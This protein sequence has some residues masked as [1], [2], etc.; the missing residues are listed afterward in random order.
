LRG[1]I[2]RRYFTAMMVSLVFFLSRGAEAGESFRPIKKD[3]YPVEDAVLTGVHPN[4][5]FLLDT[6]SS[7]TF[8]PSGI[9]PDTGD[10][11]SVATRKALVDAGATYGAG[12]RPFTAGG[13]EKGADSW[14]SRYGRDVYQRNNIIGN[15]DCYYTPFPN[16]PY[17]LT[18][19]NPAWA[20]W[21]G[22][23]AY[24]ANFPGDLKP[25][26]PGGAREGNPVPANLTHHLIPNDSRMYQMKLALW[27]ILGQENAETF[28]AMRVAMATS[29]KEETYPST[30]YAD[31]YFNP[32][33]NGSWPVRG[34]NWLG[35]GTN[36]AGNSA[37]AGIW[38]DYYGAGDTSQKWA[39]VNRAVLTAPFDYIYKQKIAGDGSLSYIA[40]DNLARIHE[41]L[42]GIEAGNSS[43]FTNR[44]LYAD[45]KT[46][47]ATSIYSRHI[48]A[49]RTDTAN[50]PV[51][52]YA[53]QIAGNGYGAGRIKFGSYNMHIELS[54]FPVSEDL[55][56]NS[57]TIRAG[58]ALG[59]VIDFF[60]PPSG[61]LAYDSAPNST[62]TSNT[63]GYFP[64]LGSCQ[65]NWLVV[66]TAAN[67]STRGYTAAQAA[68]RLFDD[69]RTHMR[70]R[71][72]NGTQWVEQ[73]FTMD[74]GIRTLV[75]GMVDPDTNDPLVVD[76]RDSLNELARAGD[77]ILSNGVYVPN[78]H[79]QA[80]FATDVPQ[81]M[82][83]LNSIL[84]RISAR[85]F[86][87]G[88]PVVMP[89]ETDDTNRKV[90]F[91]SS[92][93]INTMDQWDAWFSRYVM[94]GDFDAS[95]AWEFNNGA[96]VP[97]HAARSIYTP[98]CPKGDTNTTSTLLQAIAPSDMTALTGVPAERV[99]DF[100]TWLRDY[101]GLQI[102]GD[103]ENSGMQYVGSPDVRPLLDD[104]LVG[105][106]DP[107]VYLQTNRGV[108][109]AVNY[110]NGS[111]RWAFFPPN[112]F[113]TRLRALKFSRD[114]SWH[115]GD[116]VNTVRSVAHNL[117]DGP[118]TFRDVAVNAA[119]TDYRTILIGNMGWGGNGLYAMD[120][121]TPGA[122]PQFLWAVE[123][124]RYDGGPSREVGL[125]GKS[126]AKG[127][128]TAPYAQLGLTIAPTV[129][130]S[131]DVSATDRRD[132]AVL[133]GGMGYN[134]GSDDQGKALYVIDPSDGDVLRAFTNTSG[135]VGPKGSA[136]GMGVAPIT[137]TTESAAF[138]PA[139]GSEGKTAFFT[140]DSEGNVLYCNTAPE[141]ASWQLRS[142]FQLKSAAGAPVAIPKAI[143]VGKNAK[144]NIWLFGGSAPL[145]AP[146]K[147]SEGKQRGIL[148][149]QNCIFAFNWTKTSFDPELTTETPGM[150]RLKY[151]KDNSPLMPP[152]GEDLVSGDNSFD[153]D[154]IKGWY[155]PL[156]PAQSM[157]AMGTMPEYV[158]TSPYLYYGTLYVTTFVPR[159]RMPNEYD[160]C[161]DLG[162]AK[163]YALNPETGEG[164]WDDGRGGK[165]V[166]A[167][168]IKDVKITG[169][170][171]MGGRMY[172]GVKILKS[173]ALDDLPSQVSASRFI[174]PDRTMW[175]FGALN[176]SGERAPS[177][178]TDAP[179]IQ[180]WKDII[181]R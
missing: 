54:N 154:V 60:S 179:Y 169:M 88:A 139:A 90:L 45:G 93:R 13:T 40:T 65:S 51:V 86:S 151:A 177:L 41:F 132:V 85:K 80:Y 160:I 156:R 32:D 71:Y 100:R 64:I 34:P 121:T 103:M 63:L 75:V 146:D 20:N 110:E 81:L 150:E 22:T 96:L 115:G 170:T 152:Y 77:P 123:N 67:D 66:F 19:R 163:I 17:F 74:S 73:T 125:W 25:Y 83:S 44:E 68:T 29:Y 174:F 161:P 4:V 48:M 181:S 142:V 141:L 98:L 172:V 126:A 106:R 91:S 31:F 46:P 43:N 111:E 95:E 119:G 35:I 137:T 162:H 36:D 16:R 129:L 1:F 18:F 42:D 109:H 79:A 94:S 3:A 113:Q 58:Q 143:S 120:V 122:A 124:D 23:G 135:F 104:A 99:T 14:D 116:G 47:L 158:T 147:D 61:N 12:A 130:L 144:S 105:P 11:R 33:R 21:N 134:L 82:A 72:W 136:L 164:Q 157:G 53:S 2:L 8:T 176:Y 101:N 28:S 149:P 114:G 97:G 50:Q 148:N 62:R 138:L 168:I 167:I 89:L 26:M 78:P 52:R 57:G 55:R 38:R 166:Q 56:P 107:V 155:L 145:D 5:L 128:N 153:P 140:A 10:G 178:S 180:Y 30:L 112:I 117:L 108:L 127:L 37:Y 70:G 59:S 6:G 69:S 49:G 7:M 84:T 27:R 24:P 87:S 9:M 159:V 15:P 39:Q 173:T 165:G 76:L 131:A 171:A 92:Y 118:L 102:L 133:P 175:S